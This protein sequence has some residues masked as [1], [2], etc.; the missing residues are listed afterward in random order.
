MSL[1]P[2]RAHLFTAGRLLPVVTGSSRPEAVTQVVFV[3]LTI[4][5]YGAELRVQVFMSGCL[6]GGSSSIALRIPTE[7]AVSCGVGEQV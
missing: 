1:V 2:L 4:Q 7:A 5:V 3:F 6:R